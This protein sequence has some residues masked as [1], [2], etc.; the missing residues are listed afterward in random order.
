MPRIPSNNRIRLDALTRL[1]SVNNL[2]PN[3]MRGL[4]SFGSRRRGSTFIESASITSSVLLGIK[5][6]FVV[7]I[8]TFIESGS[9]TSS[10]VLRILL[11]I[12]LRRLMNT[13]F[14]DSKIRRLTGS[15]SRQIF[16]EVHAYLPKQDAFRILEYRF[17]HF[18][19]G[20]RCDQIRE[21]AEE[22][23]IAHARDG[24]FSRI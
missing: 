10:V 23:A 15:Q 18:F 6:S 2:F 19:L 7:S 1:D 20:G 13:T 4:L 22:L 11:G 14:T 8:S 24:V 21:Y 17:L 16:V 12:S 5:P 9:M 3:L